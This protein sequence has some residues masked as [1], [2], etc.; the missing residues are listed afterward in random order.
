MLEDKNQGKTDLES[1]GEFG[2][3]EHLTQHFPIT[4]KSTLKGIGD[5]AAVLNFKGRQTV[6]STDLLIEGVHFDLSYMPLKHLGYKAVMVNLSDIYA[7]NA[8][9]TQI[10]VS[11]AVSNRFPLEALEELYAGIALATKI[12]D[13]DLVGGDTTSSTTGLIISITAIGV[14]I[15]DEIVYRNGAKANDLL[16]VSGDLGGAYMGLQ[17]LEREKEV[18]KV[19]PNNQPD[20][21]PYSYIVERQL[22]P[23][24]RKDI[25]ELLAKLDVHPTSMIDISDGLSS[26]ILHLCKQSKVGCNLFEDKIP[27]DPTVISACEEF[28]MDSTLVALSGGEDYELLFTIDQ[29][30]FPKIKGNPNLTV[31]GHMTAENEGA[32]LISRNNSRIPLTAQGWNSF[33]KT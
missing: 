32:H 26:E 25:P 5:D 13:V 2:L 28:K 14:A 27:L 22:K 19:N 21:E 10:T 29:K 30:E 6:V 1:L 31:V 18:F 7:M 12:Y 3:I 24:A 16:V 4:Q 33:A 8:K 23:E 17:V 11:I 20:L 15:A 9:A